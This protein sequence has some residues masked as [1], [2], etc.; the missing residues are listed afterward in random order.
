MEVLF[1]TLWGI[2][3]RESNSYCT[4][5]TLLPGTGNRHTGIQNVIDSVAAI[6]PDANG[7]RG[8]ILLR[9]GA[10]QVSNTLSINTNGIVIRGEGNDDGGTKIIFTATTQRNLFNIYGNTRATKT[11]SE[12][13]VTDS[14]VPVG[15][16]QLNIEN[17]NGFIGGE[18]VIL[19]IIHSPGWNVLLGIN[20]LSN[21]CDSDP[22][23]H[24]NWEVGKEFN[25]LRKIT[26]V[27]GNLITLDAPLV[28][29]IGGL[30]GDSDY[31]FRTTIA[32]L[33]EYTWNNKLE[34]VGIENIRL[35][36]DYAN[37][38]DEDHGWIALDFKH[39]E[40]AWVSDVKAYYFGY[41][42]VRVYDG[43]YQITVQNSGMYNY[44]SKDR[45]AR[46]CGFKGVGVI[47]YF[48]GSII[49]SFTP[50][51]MNAAMALSRCSIL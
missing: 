22:T 27:D 15:K 34:E 19:T 25:Y 32:T 40:N 42:N 35:D 46:R 6:T 16:K 2:I 39:I 9:A 37:D 11:G 21:Y 28:D 20:D 50:I 26:N 38:T 45:S 5:V 48:L 24:S 23:K 12:R 47:F 17:G 3:G 10:Y 33:T 41:S 8:A 18:R 1:Q 4:C 44:K 13:Q 14:Y 29:P 7:H 31:L 51:L 49:F 30:V 43:S 36:S